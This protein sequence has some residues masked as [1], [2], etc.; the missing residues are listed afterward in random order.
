M[1]NGFYR[2]YGFGFLFCLLTACTPIQSPSP[3]QPQTTVII[4]NLLG[5]VGLAQLPNGGLLIAEEGSGERDQSAG[6]T[7][8]MNPGTTEQTHGRLVSGLPSTRDAGDLA[9]VPLVSVSPDGETVYIGNFSQEHLWTLPV[10]AFDGELPA[11]SFMPDVLGRTLDKLN[12]VR[13]VNPF[14][15]T[16][17]PDGIPVVSDASENGVATANPNGTTRFFHRFDRIP[18]PQDKIYP[19]EAVPTGITRVERQDR[20]EEYYVTLFGGCPYPANSGLLVAID[21]ARNQ[22]TVVDGLN[23]PIDVAQGADGTIWVLEFAQFQPGASCFDGSGYLP[24]T[25]RL[26]IVQADGTLVT[27]IDRLDFPGAVLPAA[28]GSLYISEV[29]RGRVIQIRLP[30]L[31]DA[32]ERG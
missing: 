29:F 23:L 20:Q 30:E 3:S 31:L 7:F 12:N 22:R 10:S 4:D 1:R 8:V 21:K 5:P 13:L 2:L 25:G 28:D 24:E 11:T 19:V 15:M 6:V 32:D 17:D 14:D 27:V 16:Y 18:D 9:G 26:S